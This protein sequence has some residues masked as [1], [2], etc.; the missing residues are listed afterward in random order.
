M[1]HLLT[2]LRRALPDPNLLL[3]ANDR[4]ALD[5][6]RVWCDIVA[7]RQSA[8]SGTAEGL[9]YA[10]DLYRGAFLAG[11]SL[12]GSPEYEAWAAQ[13]QRACE[14]LYL[15][16]LATLVD[17]RTSGGD[18]NAAILYAKRYLE[19]DDLAEDIHRRLME[20]YAATGDR[21][22]ALRQFERC[23]AVLERELNVAPLPETR[24]VYQAILAGQPPRHAPKRRMMALPRMDT[25][26]LGRQDAMRRLEE[27]HR[28][29]SLGPGQVILISGEAGVGKSRL[30]HEFAS[31]LSKR[32]RVLI[33]FGHPETRT[34]PYHPIIQ[35][36][37]ALFAPE[38]EA[39][40]AEAEPDSPTRGRPHGVSPVWLTEISRLLPELRGLYPDLPSPLPAQPEEARSRLFDALCKVMRDLA[41]LALCLDDLHHA[42]STTLDW[43]AHLGRQLGS[44]YL[45]VVGVYRS[46]E[47]DVVSGLRH[48][49]ALTGALQ[50]LQLEGLD[51][52][53]VLKLFRHLAGTIPGD[54]VFARRLW[55]ITGGNPFFVLETIRSLM[56]TGRM[57]EALAD[58]DNLP[59]PETVVQAVDDRLRRLSPVARQVLQAAAIAG[60]TLSLDLVRLTAGRPE[61]ETMD[62]LD[63]LV[64]QQL[65]VESRGAPQ[66]RPYRFHHELVRRVVYAGLAPTRRQLLHRRAGRALEQLEPTAAAA[67]AHHF[68]AGGE[69]T[70]ALQYHGLAARQAADMFAWN[71]T[72][73]H[74]T[75]MLALLDY[76]DPDRTRPESLAQR[77]RVLADRA[78]LRYVSGRLDE[79]D[80]D[81]QALAGL[82]EA[83]G[84]SDLCL[85]A[86]LH[87]TRYLNLAG[88]YV[89]A[90]GQAQATLQHIAPVPVPAPEPARSML[91]QILVEI[92]FA[93]YLLGQ[94]RQGLAALESALAIAGEK[95]G[96]E[97]RGP[98]AHNLGYIY[99]HTGDYAQAL[100]YQQEAEACH[101]AA[102]D[103]NGVAWALLDMGLLH[104]KLGHSLEAQRWLSESL[105]LARRIGARPAEAY[106]RTYTAYWELHQGFYAIAAEHLR[107][108]VPL[109]LEMHQAHGAAAAEIGL[110]LALHH[111]GSNAEA[112]RVLQS[113]V[114]RARAVS[115]R[116]RLAEALIA[117][118]LVEM[119]GE[120]KHTA[121]G[122]LAEAIDI[123]RESEC[124][125]HLAAGFAAQARAERHADNLVGA[126]AC[127]REAI[128]LAG[129]GSLPVGRMWG[130]TEAGLALLAQGEAAAALEHTE[131]AVALAHLAHE[132][133]I[134]SEEVYRAHARVLH[135]LGRGAEAHAYIQKA[136]AVIRDKAHRIP[137]PQRRQAYLRFVNREA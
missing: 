74:Q 9:R 45:L 60:D 137:N 131:Q 4:V 100:A 73:E 46:E 11:F 7:F 58:A 3:I 75:R 82:A 51:E 1:T 70:K 64:A 10:V 40:D 15:R 103:Y 53:V 43:L 96:P 31:R 101:R 112:R 69:F 14:G 20:L 24:E 88:Q 89:E 135:T 34:M 33:G 108:C 44:S 134:G 77:G 105:A 86:T 98:I 118:G 49:L 87:R 54:E 8:E 90:I 37:R 21:H 36:L 47:A 32:A 130:E 5:A 29:A 102:G 28:R 6:G 56:Q 107:E 126:L 119:E 61:L 52:E 65:L 48:S 23:I 111:L 125:E 35:A 2:H 114:Q 97:I 110:G 113:A 26:M 55:K 76:L 133:W 128:R 67:L 18:L 12:P 66:A 22:A 92:G 30:L 83:S 59:L 104:L 93:H 99:L 120:E 115:H 106:A 38:P 91:C 41:P 71:E 80:A 78:H 127:A 123:A 39:S 94:P 109:H 121:Q 42:D 85:L 124:R 136:D 132:A 116:R 19:T 117:L 81:V 72:E 50:E 95:A 68:E 84:D 25:P 17:E 63:E 16:T 79:R 129:E 13:E 57:R 27:A 62:G 122:L